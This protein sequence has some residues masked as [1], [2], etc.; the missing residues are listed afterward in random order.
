[1]NAPRSWIREDH[2]IFADNAR[3]FFRDRWVP[4]LPAWREAGM[5]ARGIWAEAAGQGLLCA[6]IPEAYGG[7]GGDIGHELILAEVQGQENMACWG[8]QIHSGIVAHYLLAYGTEEQKQRFLPRMARG[9]LVAAIAMT[10]PGTGSDLQAVK[11][12]AE[13]KGNGWSLTGQKTFITNG[14]HANFIV[15]VA[16]TD[17]SAGSKGISLMLLETDN[18]DGSLVKGFSRGRNLDKAGMKAQDTSELFFDAVAI[19]PENLLGM[20]EGQGFKQLMQQLPQ[21]RLLVAALGVGAMDRAIADTVA[22]TKT[23]KAFGQTI[24]DFQNTRFKLAECKA[25]LEVSRAF[26]DQC[27]SALMAGALTNEAAAMAKYW[28]TDAQNQVLDDCVQLHGGYGYM[29]EYAVTEMWTDAR[30]QRIYAGTNEIMKEIIAR[31]L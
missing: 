2:R 10:E 19:P 3:R 6:S 14:Q 18:P 24:F 4:H 28:I 20:V 11:T 30:V 9:E 7:A 5:M 17:P 23:R 25:K 16:K 29:M 13:R 15:V 31:S 8:N 12:R 1:M 26:L 27:T 21:E 22:Y